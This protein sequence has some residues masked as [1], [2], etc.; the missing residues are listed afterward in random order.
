MTPSGNAIRRFIDLANLTGAGAS[1]DRF[2]RAAVVLSLAAIGL[3]AKGHAQPP[4]FEPIYDEAKVPAYTLPDVLRANDGTTIA[5][6]D[7]WPA[8]RKEWMQQLA[9]HEYGQWDCTDA[10]VE[11]RQVE[12]GPS[13]GGQAIRSQWDVT[14]SNASASRTIQWL[15]FLPAAAAKD[16]KVPIF[17]LLNFDGNHAV[18][19]DPEVRIPTS[20]FDPSDPHAVD[21]RASEKGRGTEHRRWPLEQI[22]QAGFGVATAYYGDLAPDD[23]DRFSDGLAALRPDLVHGQAAPTAGGAIAI[24][25]WGLSRLLDASEQIE[26][27]DPQRVT[28]V[29]HSR[30]GKTALWAGARDTRFA[31]VISNNSGCGGAALSRRA[32]G[33]TVGR[34]NDVF[35]HWFCFGFRTYNQNEAACP[36]DQHVLLAMIAPRPLY[37]ASA[38]KDQWADPRG[39]RLALEAAGPVYRLLGKS[40]MASVE[41]EANQAI[42]VD[43]AA[44]LHPSRTFA[45]TAYHL[46]DGEH[47][48]LPWDWAHYLQFAKTHFSG[49]SR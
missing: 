43:L 19:N 40:T 11:V 41:P 34:I 9:D 45:T 14:I 32:F 16:A 18:C 33:E 42:F 21:G 31:I 15:V 3:P 38:S 20:W 8:R 6:A 28:L 5:S 7:Q 48:L 24:W 22:I 25:A 47:D 13:L 37:V 26:G 27:I 4:M 23:A 12:R 35:P 1:I 2:S 29:G 49:V 36:I 10:A 44:P 39:E 46:R 17:L 30:L